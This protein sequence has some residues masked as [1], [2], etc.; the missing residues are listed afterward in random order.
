MLAGPRRL[1]ED[2]GAVGLTVSSDTLKLTPATNYTGTATITVIVS[3]NVL[4]DTT[5]FNFIVININDS[6]VI[7]SIS[8]VTINEDETGTATLSATD[9]DGDALTYS[10]FADAT[11]ITVNASNDTLKLTP[12]ANWNGT[13]TITAIASDGT[14]KD[15]TA[16]TLSVTAVNDAPV[17]TAVANDSTNEE[18]EKAIVLS[19]TSSG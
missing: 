4:T 15:S 14:L 10:G 11:A 9:I 8:D 12:Q 5:S 13:S 19:T 17:I 3:D 6:P 7:S 18:T 2:P 1:S 16:F